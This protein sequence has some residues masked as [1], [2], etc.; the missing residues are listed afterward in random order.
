MDAAKRHDGKAGGA[1]MTQASKAA[2]FRALHERPG[3]FIIPNPWDAGTAKILGTAGFE[4]MATTSAGFGFSVGR[5]NGIG[6]LR[7]DEILD[8]AR[9]IVR[10]SDLPVTGDL[11]NGFADQ[12]ED[13]ADIIRAAA[14][15]GLVGASIE[16]ATGRPVETI[17]PFDLAV[18]RVA[19]AVK[20]ARR[21]SHDFVVTARAENLICGRPDLGDTIR[22]LQ[23]FADAGADVLYAP[24][25]R[26][27]DEIR[28]VVDAVAPRPLNVVVGL[29]GHSLSLGELAALGVK[30]VSL[31]STLARAAFGAF[32]RATDEMKGR[33]TFDFAADA[34]PYRKIVDIFG[35]APSIT[36]LCFD[37]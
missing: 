32:I 36:P 35:H 4:A 24:G 33:G 18:G 29:T 21:L 8:N 30:R 37:A 15:A 27:S 6:A 25:L 20:A 31:G 7:P 16:D 23:A 14:E 28:A 17:Y 10:A 9:A 5:P 11:E 22:R 13:C 1:M 26:T 19:A 12:P 34:I 3:A 2:A